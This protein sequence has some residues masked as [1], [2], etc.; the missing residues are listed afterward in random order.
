MNKPSVI[1]SKVRFIKG[2]IG[3]IACLCFFFPAV[4][5][6]VTMDEALNRAV[7]ILK[8]RGLSAQGDFEIILEIVN[9]DSKN[10]DREARIIQ[11]STF[12]ALHKGFPNAKI[13]L[14]NEAI[15]G[16]SGKAVFIK[17]TYQQRGNKVNV[18]LQ[19][20]NQTSGQLIAKAEVDYDSELKIARDMVA[21]LGLQ[22]TNLNKAQISIFSKV[23]RSELTKTGKM[24]LIASEYIDSADADK[25]QHEYQ[26]T[27]DEC[28][29]IIAQQLNASQVVTP[30]YEKVTENL[31]YLVASWKDIASGRTLN[32]VSIEHNC[33][34]ETLGKAMEDLACRLA[35]TCGQ[36]PLITPM[37]TPAP[38]PAP[39]PEPQPEPEPE[40]VPPP[41]P[42][43]PTPAF[44]GFF[45]LAFGL[46][47]GYSISEITATDTNGNT[48]TFDV[49][50]DGSASGYY[51]N[52]GFG[53]SSTAYFGLSWM[54]L[55]QPIKT[56]EEIY[57]NA[58]DFDW[59][60]LI[61]GHFALGFGGG[62]NFSNIICD[63]CFYEAGVGV[64]FLGKIGYVGDSVGVIY[65]MHIIGSNATASFTD[66]N[67]TK[68]SQTY[69]WGGTATMLSLVL[70]F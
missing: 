8:N 20:I 34:L 55:S 26:C 39:V 51:I 29:T 56:G 60:G 7:S 45:A 46:P 36:A 69:S 37:A 6:A 2:C 48:S 35:G 59:T 70:K 50:A 14:Q 47:L 25:I 42:Y 49:E 40:P 15:A 67:G 19:A 31:C 24:N 9:Y 33:K 58:F 30:I 18:I 61:G 21:V 12:T 44:E 28:G 16:V 43:E 38:Q 3:L 53:Y 52:F 41:E 32:E 23:F 27:R 10:L 11:G 54:T 66:S 1:R 17:G 65:S 68:Q 13:I 57:I 62:L 63:T 22:A 5:G 4:L 64:Q